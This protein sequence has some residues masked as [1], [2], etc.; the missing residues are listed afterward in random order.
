MFASSSKTVQREAS[1]EHISSVTKSCPV[2]LFV[3]GVSGQVLLSASSPD[4][5]GTCAWWLDR[6]PIGR[7]MALYTTRT[8]L[9]L[10][11]CRLLDRGR[12]VVCVFAVCGSKTVH[13]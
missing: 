5:L 11:A 13:I 12:C 7:L 3:K 6:S 4:E 1:L 2:S 9:I 8:C 10:I